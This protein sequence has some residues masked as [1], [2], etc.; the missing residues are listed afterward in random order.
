[1]VQEPEKQVG[2][3]EAVEG[4]GLRGLE[5]CVGGRG[6]GGGME[7]GVGGQRMDGGCVVESGLG[8]GLGLGLVLAE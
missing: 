7:G 3:E 8:L 6:N 4:R 5:R 1:M 2:R